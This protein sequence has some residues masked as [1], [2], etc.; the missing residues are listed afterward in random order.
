MKSIMQQND[1]HCYLC[2]WL[3]GDV[4]VKDYLEEHHAIF[5][6]AQRKLSERYG[7]KVYLCPYH[8][9][10][11]PDAV[12]V[13]NVIARAVKAKAQEAFEENFPELDFRTIFGKNYKL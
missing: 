9:R 1:G 2:E 5:G 6:T 10:L 12:H 8:H 7:L 11:G 13:N 3:N 4:S